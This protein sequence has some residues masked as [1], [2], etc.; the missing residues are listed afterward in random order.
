MEELEEEEFIKMKYNRDDEEPVPWPLVDLSYG[1]AKGNLGFYPLSQF[2]VYK[3]IVRT[4]TT[5]KFPGFLWVSRNYFHL[6]WT[7]KKLHRRLK[8]VIVVVEW[9]P[10]EVQGLGLTSIALNLM[11]TIRG[12]ESAPTVFTAAQEAQLTKCFEIFDSD[13]DGYLTKDDLLQVIY[14]EIYQLY[15]IFLLS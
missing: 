13:D 6:Q 10:E 9:E 8:N 2:A 15:C 12:G 14:M 11:K 4:N 7:L 5:L 1:P 3:N